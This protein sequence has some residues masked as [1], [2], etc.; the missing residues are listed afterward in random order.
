MRMKL[1]RIAAM[2]AVALLSA[3]ATYEPI[4]D[5]NPEWPEPPAPE[6]NNGAIYQAGYDIALFE[7]ATAHRVGDIVT[8]RLVESTA[9]SKSS[10][11]TLRSLT[12]GAPLT[13]TSSFVSRDAMMHFVT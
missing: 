3:C 5:E 6:A 11:T 4:D 12:S 9:A 7:N 10:S 2:L 1:T 8:I 13:I